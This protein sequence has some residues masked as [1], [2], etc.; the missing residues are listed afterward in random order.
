LTQGVTS[1]RSL[2]SRGSRATSVNVVMELPRS[3][4]YE[5]HLTANHQRMTVRDLDVR[6]VLQ[7]H[8][9]PGATIDAGLAGAL[10]IRVGG[11]SY[12]AEVPGADDVRGGTTVRL[13]PLRS[14]SIT[15][16]AGVGDVRLELLGDDLGLDVTTSGQGAH[17]IAIGPAEK[18][19]ST[20]GARSERTAGFD[21]ASVRVEALVSSSNGLIRVERGRNRDR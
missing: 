16:R 21:R 8:A 2:F 3:G 1:F 12:E 10:E 20:A 9:S 5:L 14:G 7:G 18:R 13:R 6:G 4:P 11:V 19:P 17:E 15:V